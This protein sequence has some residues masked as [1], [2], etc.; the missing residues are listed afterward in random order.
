M[1]RDATEVQT[2]S[3]APVPT[4]AAPPSPRVATT[5]HGLAAEIAAYGEDLE[6][7][8]HAAR[9]AWLQAM[10]AANSGRSADLAKLAIAQEAYEAVAT[11]RE[12]WIDS[13]RVAV[14]IRDD[15]E[16]HDVEIALDQEIAWQKVLQKPPKRG[17]ADRIRRRL[18]GR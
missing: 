17:I 9:D 12:H 1:K 11:E 18:G 2:R 8:Y 14:P 5:A 10:H 13:G 4:D 7:R 16:R 3:S 15:G 6:S